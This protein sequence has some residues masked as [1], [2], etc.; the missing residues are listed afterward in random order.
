MSQREIHWSGGSKK[1]D[2]KVQLQLTKYP[3]KQT[4]RSME[5][6]EQICK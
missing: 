4:N 1:E 5:I 2:A 6:I 3:I